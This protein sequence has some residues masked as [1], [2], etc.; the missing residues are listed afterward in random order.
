MRQ[1]PRRRPQRRP[2]PPLPLLLRSAPPAGLGVGA[3]AP[4]GEPAD[5]GADR[6]HRHL[7]RAGRA[8]RH[9]LPARPDR[10]VRRAA[11]DLPAGRPAR[12][13]RADAPTSTPASPRTSR[14]PVRSSIAQPGDRI[15]VLD[16]TRTPATH[17]ILRNPLDVLIA[18]LSASVRNREEPRFPAGARGRPGQAG[19]GS[20]T[21]VRSSTSPTPSELFRLGDDAARAAIAALDVEDRARPD[22]RLRHLD[23]VHDRRH[24]RCR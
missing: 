8:P 11:R 16:V 2:P 4:A 12:P 24:D 3:D 23:R 5:P 9:R 17:R 6:H 10:R 1:P 15:W 7:H 20:T 21:A 19:R 22:R 13:D 18:S 14:S